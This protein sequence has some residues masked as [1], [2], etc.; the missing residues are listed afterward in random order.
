MINFRTAA[1]DK[2]TAPEQLDQ[3]VKVTTPKAWIALI[4]IGVIIVIVTIW[5]VIGT[6]ASRVNSTGIIITKGGQVIDASAPASGYLTRLHVTL[7]DYVTAGDVIGEIQLTEATERKT[8][9]VEEV[10]QRQD[11]LTRTQRQVSQERSVT[12]RNFRLSRKRLE[13]DLQVAE[14]NIVTSK[15]KLEDYKQ[16]FADQVVTRQALDNAQSNYDRAVQQ[17]SQ[18]LN[19]LDNQE[20]R[21]L[22]QQANYTA[23][24]QQAENLLVTGQRRLREIEAVLEANSTVK[25]PIS[26]QVTEIKVATGSLIGGG[27]PVVSVESGG[28]GLEVLAYIIAS[29]GKTVKQD[30]DVLVDPSTV[31]K[32]EYGALKGKIRWVSEF[33]MTL[34][35]VLA[36]L[37]NRQLAQQFF[38][39]GAPFEARIDLT[40]DE[41]SE[42]GYAWTS[43]KGRTV[44]VSSGTQVI[45][46][47]T[48]SRKAPITLVIP[49]LKK[50]LGGGSQQIEG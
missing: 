25:A 17:R 12:D 8:S 18:I 24:V 14:N 44:S 47:I 23:R 48:T 2:L 29:Q 5:S 26:G 27:N 11:E 3:I 6:I 13:D 15:E 20:A 1:L 38:V 36:T 4:A 50:L 7:G 40:P 19:N 32:E 37:Q 22:E 33:P 35:G 41:D 31:T 10:R 46:E 39:V 30:M 34:E 42:S 45:V 49:L 16:L 28:D 21:E 43:K 9:A